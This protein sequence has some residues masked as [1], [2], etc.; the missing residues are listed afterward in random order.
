MQ[1]SKQNSIQ[2]SRQNSGRNSGRK[3]SSSSSSSS[4]KGEPLLYVDVNF[5]TNEKTR[6]ALYEK[7]DPEKV[8]KKFVKKHGLD[9]Q[10]QT[11]LVAL[12]KEQL[13]SA[14]TNIEEEQEHDEEEEQEHR[15]EQ[16]EEKEEDNQFADELLK[17]VEQV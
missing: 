13:A 9:S 1:N 15:R 11:N 16:Q 7:S 5:G 12:L 3:K 2:N 17:E 4:E 8:A 14:L 10:I 6:I